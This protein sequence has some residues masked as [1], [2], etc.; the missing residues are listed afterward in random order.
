MA[1]LHGCLFLYC[2]PDGMSV[3]HPGDSATNLLPCSQGQGGGG[4][5][6][7]GTMETG[8]KQRSTNLSLERANIHNLQSVMKAVLAPLIY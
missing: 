2:P 7:G 5:G 3:A 8:E 1:A 4:G 6:G